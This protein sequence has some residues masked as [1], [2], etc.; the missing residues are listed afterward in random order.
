MSP[1]SKLTTFNPR[2]E[3]PGPNHREA[4]PIVG[5]LL[6]GWESSYADRRP[7][8]QPSGRAS[9]AL[10]VREREVLGMISQ[11]LTNK[12]I[13]RILEISP[14]TVKT[15]VKRIFLKLAVS[16]RAAAVSRAGSLGRV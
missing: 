12:R 7:A 2:I 1:D 3:A 15:H 14:E 4:Q 16:T 5:L 8:Q 10:T 6:S 13:A 9:D 11:G